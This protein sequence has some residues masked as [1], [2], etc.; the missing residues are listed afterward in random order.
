M[1]PDGVCFE[2]NANKRKKGKNTQEYF[3]ISKIDKIKI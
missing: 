3:L 1:Y 2:K